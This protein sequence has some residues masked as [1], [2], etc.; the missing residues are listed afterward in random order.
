MIKRVLL[1]WMLLKRVKCMMKRVKCMERFLLINK[2]L[3]HTL[4]LK[5]VIMM[6]LSHL[7]WMRIIC[8]QVWILRLSLTMLLMPL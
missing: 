2:V 5:A 8:R 1:M 7:I 6:T 4:N 3:M